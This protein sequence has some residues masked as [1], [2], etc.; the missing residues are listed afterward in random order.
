MVAVDP[1]ISMPHVFI[2]GKKPAAEWGRK[3][4]RSMP[5]QWQHHYWHLLAPPLIVP[6]FFVIDNLKTV[7]RKRIQCHV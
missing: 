6:I 7:I 3:K 4:R 2:L 1:D 5:Y